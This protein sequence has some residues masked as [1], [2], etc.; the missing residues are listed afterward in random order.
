MLHTR[1]VAGSIPAGTTS[2]D[3]CFVPVGKTTIAVGSSPRGVA[4]NPAGTHAYVSSQTHLPCSYLDS[5]AA[6]P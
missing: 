5:L 2:S 3:T 1:K 4:V 6:A